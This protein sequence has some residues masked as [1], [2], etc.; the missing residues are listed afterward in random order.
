[1]IHYA[2]SFYSGLRQSYTKLEQNKN[3]KHAVK[4]IIASFNNFEDNLK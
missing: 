3:E 4:L 2:V 1:M